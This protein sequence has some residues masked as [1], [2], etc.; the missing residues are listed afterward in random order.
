MCNFSRCDLLLEWFSIGWLNRQTAGPSP[1]S[2]L[3]P[4]GAH[5]KVTDA[6]TPPKPNLAFPMDFPP[7]VEL[8]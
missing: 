5:T 1:P 3:T 8:V 2:H 4:E 6:A 7:Q